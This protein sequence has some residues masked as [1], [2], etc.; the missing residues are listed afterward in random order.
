VES[1][2]ELLSRIET[3]RLWGYFHKDWLIQVRLALRPQLPA[4]YRVFVVSEAVLITPDAW[5]SAAKTVLPDVA[6]AR[7]PGQA[8]T[9][10]A[11]PAVSNAATAII[12]AAEPCETE[13]HYSLVIRRAPDNHV[14]AAAELL[15]PS[16]KGLGNRLDQEKH[17]RKRA[18]YF[19]AGISLLEIDALTGGQRVLPDALA[20]L[21]PFDRVVWTAFHDA[22]FRRYRGMGWNQ[23]DPLPHVEWRIDAGHVV[24]IDLATTLRE[25]AEFNQWATLAPETD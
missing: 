3:A 7:S 14:V 4:D 24:Q 18:E 1:L 15:S 19:D 2:N 12:E 6:V 22:G 25:A 23:S 11:V 20:R 17:L 9:P 13:I 21:Q 16:N 10:V 5:D 8:T